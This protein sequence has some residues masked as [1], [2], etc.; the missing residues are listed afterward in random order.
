M[1]AKVE[2]RGHLDLPVTG[3]YCASCALAIEKQLS[4]TPGVV[5]ASVNFA[6]S[7]ATVDFD[8]R[9]TARKDLAGAIEQAGY[10]SEERRVGKECRS[11]WSP[12]H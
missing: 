4:A 2:E 8:S 7:T 9:L 1:T 3:M 10:R 6:T 5:K 12:Y 11:R